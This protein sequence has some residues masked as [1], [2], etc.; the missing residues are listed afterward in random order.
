MSAM[1]PINL[2]QTSI[3]TDFLS[4][5][6]Q[7]FPQTYITASLQSWCLLLAQRELRHVPML[8][9]CCV[10]G[11]QMLFVELFIVIIIEVVFAAFIIIRLGNMFCCC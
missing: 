4:F 6:I 1:I 5:F 2:R 9:Q 3:T 11:G 7:E 10:Q 8:C